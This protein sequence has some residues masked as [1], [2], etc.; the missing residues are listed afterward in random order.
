M[1]EMDGK[2]EDLVKD[3]IQA[4]GRLFPEVLCDGKIDFHKLRNLL[5]DAIDNAGDRYNFTW[6][7]K[8]AALRL[9]QTPS[10]GTLR[11]C[12]EE[13]KDWDTT[14]NL[15]IEGDNLEVLKLLQ[16]SYHGKVKMIYIDPPYNTGGDFVYPDDFQDSIANYKK[17]TGQTDDKGKTYSTN[18]ETSGRFHTDW[19]NM[20]YPRLR[21]ARNLLADDGVIFLSIDYNENARLRMCCDEIFG[22]ENFIGEIYWE[23]KTKSQNTKTSYNKLQPKAEMIF[24]YAKHPKYRFNLIS[25]G[26][27]EYPL[28]DEKGVYR[29]YPV[30]VM[31]ANGNRGRQSMIFPISADGIS[32]TPPEGKQWQI[33]QDT[34]DFYKE[35]NDI[36]IRDNKAIIKMR[37]DYEKSEN[38]EPFW[39]FFSKEFGTAESAKKEL[40]AIVENHGF[41][42]V[43]PVE[44]IKRL[45]FHV[46]D[47]DSIV[48]DFF[49]GSG[50]TAQAVMQL[51]SEDSGNR[52][53]IMVQ[54][55]EPCSADSMPAQAGYK[56]IC[57]I[58]K[59][60]IR[61]AGQSIVD[62]CAGG[63][64]TLDVGFRVF[65]L[66][67]S[68]LKKW[69]P[70]T[71]AD[72]LEQTLQES[73]N[74]IAPGRTEEDL[75]YEIILKMG[76]D[77][78][79]PIECREVGGVQVFV[80]A[81]GALF[82]CLADNITPAVA[83]GMVK[84]HQ[85]LAPEVWKVVCRDTGFR[86][87]AAKVNVRE[88]LK[89]EGLDDAAFVT[90]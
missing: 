42:T 73:V 64:D 74:N 11:P 20:I 46:T 10:L 35:R 51:N 69:Q 80:V 18:S 19:L 4:L 36:F 12:K 23:S 28:T 63:A 17:V 87:D 81:A 29:E 45:V 57:E 79:W 68:N 65:K 14:Q 82:I 16:K 70:P 76:F 44:I 67:T 48:L 5:G 15:Y 2:S 30:E 60:R 34:V 3:N 22:E 31:N 78:S 83:E 50:T 58:A 39:G 88:I 71:D 86:D 38:T 77:L 47:A 33:G 54:L 75:L 85:E 66:D 72:N 49:S 41:D 84:L 59:E 27:K 62:G 40:S 56:N 32:V 37:P 13:S 90:V 26:E 52:R 21:L 1:T 89:A 25:K 61:R 6:H 43:K 24:V 55:P 9:S 8:D 53:F 7:G